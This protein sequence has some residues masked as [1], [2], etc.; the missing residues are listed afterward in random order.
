MIRTFV[1]VCA[2]AFVAPLVVAEAPE[3]SVLVAMTEAKDLLAAQRHAEAVARLEKDLPNADGYKPYL[4]LLRTAYQAEMAEHQRLGVEARRV[5]ELKTRLALLG[6]AKAEAPVPPPAPTTPPGALASGDDT[7]RQ[8]VATFQ[9]AKAKPALFG[10]AARLF[11]AAFLSKVQLSPDQVAAWSFCRVRV[12]AS[13]LAQGGN[14]P[15]VARSVITEVEDALAQAPMNASLQKA[16]KDV[17]TAAR[18]IAVDAPTVAAVA[19]AASEDAVE[20]PS[21]RIVHHQQRALA[22][23][24]AAAAEKRRNEIFTRWSG[25]PGGAWEP[26][27]EIVLHSDGEAFSK[28][29]SQ[30]AEGTGRAI[31]TLEE[32]RVTTRRIDLRVDDATVAED[33]LPRELTHII[34]ADLF[35]RQAP[36]A[37][38]ELGM[39][40]LAASDLERDRCRRTLGRCAQKGELLPVE[41]LLGITT[42]PANRV[43]GYYVESVSLVEFLVKWKG[44]KAFTTFLRDS[45]RYGMAAALKRQY[46]FSTAQQLEEAWTK[47]ELGS[48]RA[49]A[50]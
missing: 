20:T 5:A 2:V 44:D 37:W 24:V 48:T 15:V 28:V 9:Q 13:Q 29:T 26:K 8:A 16:G 7:L 11:S 41:S 50:P 33:A 19:S 4:E 39:A 23:T 1:V 17:L 30:P 25:P 40:V 22:E 14:D 35:P 34:L 43:T 21:F 38:A 6:P 3:R 18:R 31:V 36:P 45:Q 47:G 32:G 46:G 10:E 27:C 42:P 49:Q 12:A